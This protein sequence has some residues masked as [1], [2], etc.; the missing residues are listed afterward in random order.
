MKRKH[1][2]HHADHLT[3]DTIQTA[4]KVSGLRGVIGLQP[5]FLNGN[6]GNALSPDPR[7]LRYDDLN[8]AAEYFSDSS[9]HGF[10]MNFVG[11]LSY[12][13]LVTLCAFTPSN[14][15][16][17]AFFRSIIDMIQ[18]VTNRSQDI[19]PIQTSVGTVRL[20]EN[21]HFLFECDSVR[22]PG[23]NMTISS[24]SVDTTTATD[25]AQ[26]TVKSADL[27]TL[28]DI[29]RTLRLVIQSIHLHPANQL[30]FNHQSLKSRLE[31][32]ACF[33]SHLISTGKIPMDF[34]HVA[35]VRG[36]HHGF[37]IAMAA[38]SQR[39]DHLVLVKDSEAFMPDH[40]MR[41]FP[42]IQYEMLPIQIT[43]PSIPFVPISG[44]L[45]EQDVWKQSVK[46][47]VF[48]PLLFPFK[49]ADHISELG[50]F[51]TSSNIQYIKFIES[52]SNKTGCLFDSNRLK[53][54]SPDTIIIVDS[55]YFGNT[56]LNSDDIATFHALLEHTFYTVIYLGS[57]GKDWESFGERSGY[58]ATNC[59]DVSSTL[60]TFTGGLGLGFTPDQET[61]LI[62]QASHFDSKNWHTAADNA[63]IIRMI[64]DRW[65]KPLHLSKDH[66]R[67]N[68]GPFGSVL[69]NFD[70]QP[71]LMRFNLVPRDED[72][73][74]R[75]LNTDETQ[76]IEW[77]F[78]R[79]RTKMDDVT[80][81]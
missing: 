77:L 60:S 61:F 4:F 7:V 21:G 12:A 54:L 26:L 67:L 20:I 41:L 5:R 73:R 35:H 71:T 57:L 68:E 31:F 39:F 55:T 59:H 38:L 30:P 29:E 74:I 44:D 58:I 46:T 64:Y 81:S 3:Y 76:F 62:E 37:F 23:L 18:N 51:S 48:P 25:R 72:K 70:G 53:G 2:S 47:S 1:I 56:R 69:W 24:I 65:F 17:S 15:F 75:L 19:Q 45:F 66:I 78:T 32:Q 63:K 27:S 9:Q 80:S 22:F 34:Q 13:L 11:N 28:N 49:Y 8:I 50:S 43:A 79:I 40:C 10:N 36:F 6:C 33:H 14:E 16:S 52:V 42:N